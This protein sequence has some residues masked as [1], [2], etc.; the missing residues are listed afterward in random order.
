MTAPY[1]VTVRTAGDPLHTRDHRVTAHSAWLC[2]QLH[3]GDRPVV[4]RP[5]TE[6][7]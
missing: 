2:R 4:I 6:R 3:P 7:R 5:V 1:L